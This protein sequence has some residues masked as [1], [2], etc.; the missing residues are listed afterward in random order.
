MYFYPLSPP[1]MVPTPRVGLARYHGVFAPYH[2]RQAQVTRVRCILRG[3]SPAE[4]M[5]MRKVYMT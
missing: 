3:T 4:S 2:W 5:P 1:N